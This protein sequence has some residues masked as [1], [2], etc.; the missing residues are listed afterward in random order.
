[1]TSQPASSGAPAP[2]SGAPILIIALAIAAL[3][4]AMM[5]NM[6]LEMSVF[7]IG[8]FRFL[9]FFLIMAPVAY[10]RVGLQAL[11]PARI[12][13]QVLRG[14][15]Q[16][17][18]M[19]AFVIGA[20]QMNFADAIAVLYV[21]PFLMTAMAAL[22]LGERVSTAGWAGV[23]GGFLGVL[24]V[25]R[26]DPSLFNSGALFVL[27]A[28]FLVALQMVLN[29]TLGQIADPAVTSVW[30]AFSA[31]VALTAT[32]P[33]VWSP[34]GLADLGPLGLI[35]LA[36]ACSH[37]LM[38]VAFGKSPASVLAPFTY[39]EIASAVLIGLLMFGTLPDAWSWV[40]IGLIV[41]SG[42]VVARAP[43]GRLFI[44]RQP[45]I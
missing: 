4:G 19:A 2:V 34:I 45:K 13:L 37:T 33:W 8:W 7:L 20:R 14:L 39:S 26:P 31:T 15:L 1:M 25:M 11:F 3:S 16:A 22:F 10:W 18:G 38:V 29:R 42:I 23:A 24:V 12:G 41:I 27:G 36:G 43:Q 35:A 17:M 21:Y 32:L 9:G 6:P 40:G 44:R 28:G 30:G 5:K